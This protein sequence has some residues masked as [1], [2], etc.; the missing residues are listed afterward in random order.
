MRV[1]NAPAGLFPF[2]VM[3]VRAQQRVLSHG[4]GPFGDLNARRLDRE[5]I[6]PLATHVEIALPKSPRQEFKPLGVVD[7]KCG[8]DVRVKS[9]LLRFQAYIGAVK[10][11]PG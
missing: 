10:V 4:K 9:A 8:N 6:P 5:L 2:N 11:E 1:R 3:A 7:A